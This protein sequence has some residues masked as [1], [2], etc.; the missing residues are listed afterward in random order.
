LG[1][2]AKLLGGFFDEAGIQAG[3]AGG[4][5]EAMAVRLAGALSANSKHAEALEVLEMAGGGR[6][7]AQKVNLNLNLD[8]SVDNKRSP[9]YMFLRA[10]VLNNLGRGG[11]ARDIAQKILTEY[12]ADVFAQRARMLLAK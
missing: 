2:A 12:P 5:G 9:E 4:V 3:G 8:F 1:A 10:E 11:E 7:N 6:K